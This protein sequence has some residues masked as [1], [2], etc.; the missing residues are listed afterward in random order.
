MG[1]NRQVAAYRFGEYELDLILHEIRRGGLVCSVEPQVYDLLFYLIEN[2]DRLV[3][4]DELNRHIWKGRFVTD[5]SLSTCVKL[6]RQVIG[7]NGKRQDYIRTVPRLGFRFVGKVDVLELK[8]GSVEQI[9]VDAKSSAIKVIPRLGKLSWKKHVTAAIVVAV[10]I[11]SGGV[12]QRQ[13]AISK[14]VDTA[15]IAYL[16]PAKPSIAILPF[17]NLSADPEHAFFAD[18]MAE[19]IITDLSKIDGLFVIARNSSFSYRGKGVEIGK[20]ARELNVRYVL[21]GSV[22]RDGDQVRINA[23]LIDATNSSHIWAERFDGDLS[24]IFALQ[25]GVTERVVEALKLTL[26]DKERARVKRKPTSIPQ[27]YEL[28]LKARDAVRTFKAHNLKVALSLYEKAI[29]LD[30]AFAQAYSGDAWTSALI[31][32]ENK[33]WIMPRDVA[34]KRAKQSATRALALDPDNATPHRIFAYIHLHQSQY[35]KAIQSAKLAVDMGPNDAANH[36]SL[37]YSLVVSGEPFSASTSLETGLSLE[38]RPLPHQKM[39]IGWTWFRLRQ[40]EKAIETFTA[41]REEKPELNPVWISLPLAASYAYLGQQKKAEA[42][43]RRAQGAW[44]TVNYSFYR[45]WL[46]FL[47]RKEDIEHHIEGLRRAGV[48]KWPFGFEGQEENRLSNAEIKALFYGRRIKGYT[49][50]IYEFEMEFDEFGK[51]RRQGPRHSVSG[52]SLI[53]NNLLCRW[54]EA[55][56]KGRKFCEPIYRNPSGTPD[57]RNEYIYPGIISVKEFSVVK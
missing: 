49:N 26:S 56:V 8:E 50:T 47:R 11:A 20:I 40:Y 12:W 22:R 13:L 15:E 17:E 35:A 1:S 45:P 7:D 51:W 6:A 3:D 41:A 34:L 30:P 31:W 53:A 48:P 21:E 29:N 37:A 57:Q 16:L 43:V 10:I 54:S 24:N 36:M 55:L 52:E 23:Q 14:A 9:H 42:E 44:H 38:P 25:D 2:R 19:D 18:G 46:K 28:Y 39:V 5:A 32:N 33:H 27:A 4:K